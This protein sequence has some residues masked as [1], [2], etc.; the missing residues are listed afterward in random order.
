[1]IMHACFLMNIQEQLLHIP[2]WTA[3]VYS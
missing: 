1:M 2:G 3:G